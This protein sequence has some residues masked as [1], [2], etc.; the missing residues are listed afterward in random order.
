MHIREAPPTSGHGHL[1]IDTTADNTDRVHSFHTA[2]RDDAS[3]KLPRTPESLQQTSPPLRIDRNKNLSRSRYSPSGRPAESNPPMAPQHDKVP[4]DLPKVIGSTWVW[5]YRHKMWPVVLCGD[6]IA[7]RA[8]VATRKYPGLTP[9]VLLGKRIYIWVLEDRLM[10]YEPHRV[11][12]VN[13][14]SNDMDTQFDESND[15][16]EQQRSK[17]FELDAPLHETAEFWRNCIEVQHEQRRFDREQSR[18]SSGGR[19]KKRKSCNEAIGSRSFHS[20]ARASKTP[21]RSNGYDAMKERHLPAPTTTHHDGAVDGPA[22]RKD[23]VINSNDL[24]DDNHLVD[25]GN[26]GDHKLRE[27]RERN[28]PSST[29]TSIPVLVGKDHVAFK[30]TR[31]AIENV[32]VLRQRISFSDGMVDQVSISDMAVN[33]SKT[34]FARVADFLQDGNFT[35][36][37]ITKTS[38][39]SHRDGRVVSDERD[40]AAQEIAYVYLAASHLQIERLQA[41]CLYKLR[42]LESLSPLSIL[43]VARIYV[44]SATWGC[45]AET[46]FLDW[47]VDL[48]SES[49]HLL[50]QSYEKRLKSILGRSDEL[51]TRVLEKIEDPKMGR[52]GVG[53]D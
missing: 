41:L 25:A 5:I 34:S 50:E 15:E 9:A 32:P 35:I 51:K 44:D 13:R 43:T 26:G 6:E 11:Y 29:S 23:S 22:R 27:L 53:D 3:V 20:S 8:F 19:G 38:F 12:V 14:W 31:Q 47:M 2:V 30:L 33:I 17:A 7:P 1:N 10:E 49:R 42:M 40:D 48:V 45:D 21:S 4:V 52:R 37:T 36:G 24:G 18:A 39:T 16:E 46:E 28:E